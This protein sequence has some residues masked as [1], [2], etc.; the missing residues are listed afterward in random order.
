MWAFYGDGCI[1]D[2]LCGALPLAVALQTAVTVNAI[3]DA[4]EAITACA[5][6]IHRRQ[7]LK[8]L[9]NGAR[10]VTCFSSDVGEKI[11]STAGSEIIDVPLDD[12]RRCIVDKAVQRPVAARDHHTVIVRERV[13]KSTVIV[14][15]RNI[16]E[17][18]FVI[19]Q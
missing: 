3:A 12:K 17:Q 7:L 15:F 16:L 5:V 11:I 2:R 1:I 18:N 19:G 14:D 8:V 4:V 10:C 13:K 6:H 9:V